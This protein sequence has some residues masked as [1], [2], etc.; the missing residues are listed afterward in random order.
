MLVREV[1]DTENYAYQR[2][3]L[4]DLQK[5]TPIMAE[6][7]KDDVWAQFKLLLLT[8][9]FEKAIDFIY[10]GNKLWLEA[11]HFA[12]ALAYYGL[13]RVPSASQAKT[14]RNMRKWYILDRKGKL[15]ITFVLFSY[16]RSKWIDIV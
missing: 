2:Y 3:R 16:H 9:Q 15:Y 4:Q 13:L 10:T 8:L 1:T 12:T 11:T 7:Q 5:H 14:E 6:T